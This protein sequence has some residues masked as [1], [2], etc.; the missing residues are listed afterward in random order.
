MPALFA[1][2]NAELAYE[3][4]ELAVAHAIE[5]LVDVNALLATPKAAL[6]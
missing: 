3:P 5:P 4:A 2:A 6:A 1:L